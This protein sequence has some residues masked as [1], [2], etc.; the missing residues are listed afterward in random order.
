MAGRAN[1][2]RVRH[3]LQDLELPGER[4]GRDEFRREDLRDRP[5]GAEWY[6]DE[7]FAA[8]GLTEC[9]VAEISRPCV[10]PRLDNPGQAVLTFSKPVFA[11][12]VGALKRRKGPPA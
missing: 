9:Q 4:H 12:F 8:Y 7:E 6:D 11:E 2:I 5:A 1:G 3:D 10:R